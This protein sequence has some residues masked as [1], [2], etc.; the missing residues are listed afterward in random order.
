MESYEWQINLN[1]FKITQNFPKIN[2][3]NVLKEN[4]IGTN[5]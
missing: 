2:I 3:L 1:T 5:S 4:S